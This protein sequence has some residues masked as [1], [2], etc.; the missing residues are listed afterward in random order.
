MNGSKRETIYWDT[1]VFIAW[2]SNE[3]REDLTE[4]A[5]VN[6]LIQQFDADRIILSTSVITLPEILPSQLRTETNQK[7]MRLRN[8]RNFRY[9]QTDL[10]IATLAREIRDFYSKNKDL[11][12]ATLPTPDSIHLATAIR[13]DCTYFYTFD[14]ETKKGRNVGLLQLGDTIAGKYPLNIRK[15]FFQAKA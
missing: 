2:L 4:L 12:G 10:V 11:L 7:L 8:K 9:F 3:K 1:G 14:S 15:P 6:H 13:N 5:G